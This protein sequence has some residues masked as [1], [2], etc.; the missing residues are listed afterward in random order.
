MC[1]FFIFIFQFLQNSVIS[2]TIWLKN[3][4]ENYGV[5]RVCTI[6]ANNGHKLE[7]AKHS[8]RVRYN[9][10]GFTLEHEASPIP[11]IR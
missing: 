1:E 10:S 2:A 7:R 9:A 8:D 3:V 11:A 5:D 6:E 4:V